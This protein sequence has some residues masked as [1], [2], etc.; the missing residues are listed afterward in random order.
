MYSEHP[1]WKQLITR[2][3]A[4]HERIS[5]I[6]TIFSDNDQVEMVKQLSGD[7]V[8]TFIDVLDEASPCTISYSKERLINFDSGLRILSNRRWIAFR[9]RSATGVWVI[10]TGCVAAVH[11]FRQR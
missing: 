10:Y 11:F 4:T 9:K 6:T 7:D 8:Q 5:L 1:P 2:T 3:F